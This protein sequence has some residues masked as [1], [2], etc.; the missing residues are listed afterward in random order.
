[1]VVS[2][3][4]ADDVVVVCVSFV[5]YEGSHGPS[6]CATPCRRHPRMQ[7]S[8]GTNRHSGVAVG[9]IT[10][11]SHHIVVVVGVRAHFSWASRRAGVRVLLRCAPGVQRKC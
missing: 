9:V 8:C 11:W 4:V 2:V 5:V 6:K 7:F 10:Q 1:M 3:C